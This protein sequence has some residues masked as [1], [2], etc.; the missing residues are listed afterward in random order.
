[1]LEEPG[2]AVLWIL[3]T[4]RK[5]L[6]L[7]TIRSRVVSVRFAPLTAADSLAVLLERG[8]TREDAAQLS[9]WSGGSPG[10][11]ISLGE[12]GVP[13][14]RKLLIALLRGEADPFQA[15][16]AMGMVEG[17]FEGKTPAGRERERART[18]LDLCVALLGDLARL[19]A[20]VPEAV[21]PHGDLASSLPKIAF[22]GRASLLGQAVASL[23]TIRADIELNLDPGLALERAALVM[24]A[25]DPAELVC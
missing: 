11:A 3:I 21:L 8:L 16:A 2:A 23:C 10:C 5:E 19:E 17:Q 25:K 9:R 13:L 18:V 22:A 4:D 15:A 20:G 6:L 7:E 12:R 14:L 24:A 1:M